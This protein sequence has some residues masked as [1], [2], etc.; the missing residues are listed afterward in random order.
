MDN[1]DV[2]ETRGI[3]PNKL[4]FYHDKYKAL[5]REFDNAAKNFVNRD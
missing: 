5:Y 1:I 2:L 4:I 3:D